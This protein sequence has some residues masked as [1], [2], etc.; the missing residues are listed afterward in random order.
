M[1]GDVPSVAAIILNYSTAQE[2]ADCVRGLQKQIFSNLH[3]VV[4]DN[5]S[6]DGSLE[7]LRTAFRSD[8]QVT[9]IS[10]ESNS[11]YA[12]GNNIGVKWVLAHCKPKYLFIVNPD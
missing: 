8:K 2:T 5:C 3:C 11:G 4:V 10:S 9:V 12:A 6:P 7:K 1:S